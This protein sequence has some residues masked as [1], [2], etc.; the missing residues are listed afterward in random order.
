ML[1]FPW[2]DHRQGILGR[3]CNWNPN[4]GGKTPI[5]ACHKGESMA[6][7]PESSAL[8]ARLGLESASLALATFVAFTEGP[9][10]SSDRSVYFTDLINDRILRFVLK[11]TRA[12]EGGWFETF[13]ANA[14]RPN[15]MVFD[16]Q[17]RLIVC[18][19]ELG[20]NRRVTRTQADGTITVLADRFEGRKL[21]SPNDV[22]VD[23]S[24]RV[25]FTDPRYTDRSDMELDH[26]SVYR[27]D[28]DGKLTRIIDDV[29][30]P[31]GLAVSID[32]KTLYV[33]DTDHTAGG[34]R[35][36]WAYAL[37][38]NGS[39]IGRRLVHDFGTGRGADG[40]C[41]DESGNLYVTAGLN[42]ASATEDTS[43]PAGVHV[44]TPDGTQIGFLPVPYDLVTNVTFG[45]TDLRTLYVTCGHTLL[46][47]RLNVRGHL[48]WPKAE[49]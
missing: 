41:L 1:V 8:A 15:G 26:E 35:K 47:T 17:G 43:V 39:T 30:R 25:Y 40:M 32:Q 2:V 31:N 33:V 49:A 46:H 11:G 24:G 7:T 19:G 21:N 4:R 12:S 34:P 36:L 44:F 22:D 6:A 23:A 48:L 27:V 13:R 16:A 14:G 29:S 28:A 42:I 9:C 18:E 20:Q 5:L 38:A 3:I 37:R 45:D 10:Y